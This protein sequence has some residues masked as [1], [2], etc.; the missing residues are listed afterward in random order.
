MTDEV[1]VYTG[2]EI[3]IRGP[4][5]EVI[6]QWR[7]R[8]DL[9]YPELEPHI[10]LAYPPFVP[11][12]QWELVKPV[13]MACLAGFEPFSVTLKEPG[14]FPSDS[15]QEPNVLWLK[16]EDGGVLD[17]IRRAL[18]KQ[19][20]IY[21]PPMPTP[22]IPHVS[23]GFIQGSVALEEAFAQV[24]AELQ[25]LEFT[26]TEVVYEVDD[27]GNGQRFIDAI[28]L[29][30]ASQVPGTTMPVGSRPRRRL[31]SNGKAASPG[32]NV[33]PGMAIPREPARERDSHAVR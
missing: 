8:Y 15:S 22:Y 1:L 14:V 3:F 32:K 31:R 30:G 5:A 28:P 12:E 18:E 9:T 19:L 7:R 4:T 29:L 13:V 20:P 25:P 6:N 10:S 27:K 16:P 23:I 11:L 2:L 17:R 33:L 26:V 21:V 24:Q